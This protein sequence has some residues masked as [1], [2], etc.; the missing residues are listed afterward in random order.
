MGCRIDS[1]L[2]FRLDKIGFAQQVPRCT[3]RNATRRFF[4]APHRK[5]RRT[6]FQIRFHQAVYFGFRGTYKICFHI[7]DNISYQRYVAK[8][9]DKD[10]II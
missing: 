10:T 9:N 6:I 8:E 1:V 2:K 5:M 3:L 7:I 4:S